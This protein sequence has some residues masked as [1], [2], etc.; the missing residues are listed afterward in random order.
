MLQDALDVVPWKERRIFTH[1]NFA[2]VLLCCAIVLIGS[3]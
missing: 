1:A 3:A 2:W